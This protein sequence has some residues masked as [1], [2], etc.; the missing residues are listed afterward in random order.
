MLALVYTLP[1]TLPPRAV[2][3]MEHAV[4]GTLDWE[5]GVWEA[6]LNIHWTGQIPKPMDRRSVSCKSKRIMTWNN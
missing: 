3:L 2:S 4:E 5:A 6:V 1:T